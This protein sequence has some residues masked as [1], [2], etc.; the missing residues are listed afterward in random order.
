MCISKI[1]KLP[2]EKNHSREKPTSYVIDNHNYDNFMKTTS[3]SV[4][5]TTSWSSNT[6]NLNLFFSLYPIDFKNKVK[7]LAHSRQ[8]GNERFVWI[9]RNEIM[10]MIN[11]S[12]CRKILC[13]ILLEEKSERNSHSKL[14]LKPIHRLRIDQISIKL[15]QGSLNGKFH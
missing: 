5:K 6:N 14:P 4:H 11:C 9:K 13:C 8:Y 2:H 7:S 3:I 15:K 1:T 12:C 10:F